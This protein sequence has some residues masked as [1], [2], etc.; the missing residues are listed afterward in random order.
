M[1]LEVSGDLL[2]LAHWWSRS[3]ITKF[4][5]DCGYF[6]FGQASNLWYFL[7]VVIVDQELYLA[8]LLQYDAKQ[9]LAK[10]ET[11]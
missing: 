8:F 3:A 11:F 4:G 5:F 1:D 6:Y 9:I 7:D 10:T 2:Y